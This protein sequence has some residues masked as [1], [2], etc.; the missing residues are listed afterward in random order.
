MSIF[1]FWLGEAQKVPRPG[2]G[3]AAIWSSRAPAKMASFLPSRCRHGHLDLPEASFVL[4]F[5]LFLLSAS[6]FLLGIW[7]PLADTGR[8]WQASER[9][10]QA[11]ANHSLSLSLPV[12]HWVRTDVLLGL[13]PTHTHKTSN[14][15]TVLAT[16][17]LS[18]DPHYHGSSTLLCPSTWTPGP[19]TLDLI[20]VRGNDSWILLGL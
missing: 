1:V 14:R 20:W 15:A 9:L 6:A 4:I 3:A 2:H 11:P 7:E 18:G 17:H 16:T 5:S 8:A 13:P 10:C 19:V 12:P